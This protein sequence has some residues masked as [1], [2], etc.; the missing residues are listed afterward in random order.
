[1]KFQYDIYQIVKALDF[2]DLKG[3][4]MLLG[5]VYITPGQFT[6]EELEEFFIRLFNQANNK[7]KKKIES[8][9]LSCAR[10]N[11]IGF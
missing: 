4:L 9:M 6:M 8:L 11:S 2:N 10:E 3:L 5:N 1:M 7:T